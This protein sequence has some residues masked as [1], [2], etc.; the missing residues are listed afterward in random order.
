[1]RRAALALLWLA[2]FAPVAGARPLG[3][4]RVIFQAGDWRVQ[5]IGFRDGSGFCVAEARQGEAGFS[6]WSDGRGRVRLVFTSPRW[7]F[8]G[9]AAD[10]AVRIDNRP[11]WDLGGV[12]LSG[13]AAV[14]ELPGNGR[15]TALLRQVMAGR[16]FMLMGHDDRPLGRWPLRG[17]RAALE[18]LA[19][20]DADLGRP[21][22]GRGDRG[23]AVAGGGE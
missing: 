7:H 9:G 15:G 20:C 2:A 18:A 6:V 14:F 1:M 12:R 23:R 13:Q 17:S 21:D 5:V 8:R 22:A 3:V 4:G 19:D 11:K 10:M 16:H